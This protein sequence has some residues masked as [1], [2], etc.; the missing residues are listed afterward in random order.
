MT[1]TCC[2]HLHNSFPILL[3]TKL[4]NETKKP[5]DNVGIENIVM[6]SKLKNQTWQYSLFFKQLYFYND[7]KIN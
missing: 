4:L 2:K 6:F 5:A 1:K 7:R 3:T